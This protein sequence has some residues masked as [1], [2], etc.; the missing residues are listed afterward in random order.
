MTESTKSAAE[1]RRLEST[2]KSFFWVLF[3]VLKIELE[4]ENG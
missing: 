1:R 3:S 2:R 4:V